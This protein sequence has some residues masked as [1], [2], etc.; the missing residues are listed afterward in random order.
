M[1]YFMFVL[2]KSLELIAKLKGKKLIAQKEQNKP[3]NFDENEGK[4]DTDEV[5]SSENIVVEDM[6]NITHWDVVMEFNKTALNKLVKELLNLPPSLTSRF[7]IEATRLQLGATLYNFKSVDCILGCDGQSDEELS[8]M[9]PEDEYN[10]YDDD[11]DDDDDMSDWFVCPIRF[12]DDDGFMNSDTELETSEGDSSEDSGGVDDD[13]DDGDD[14]DCHSEDDNADL[15]YIDEKLDATS[16]V[17]MDVDT[18]ADEDD[19][20]IEEAEPDQHY[21]LPSITDSDGLEKGSTVSEDNSSSAV[22][23]VP[24]N[25]RRDKYEAFS[26]DP[27]D[28][29]VSSEDESHSAGVMDAS[30]ELNVTEL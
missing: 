1:G 28:D 12:D 15:L 17:G 13:D 3:E 11:D 2:G 16:P 10:E 27:C 19:N 29:T 18:A 23:C 4:K 20:S 26:N 7:E 22:E 8:D 25:I 6:D 9:F 30:D 14:D 5:E 24:G 21:S